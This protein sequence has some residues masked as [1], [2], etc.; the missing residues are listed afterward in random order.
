MIV[1][2]GSVTLNKKF[3]NEQQSNKKVVQDPNSLK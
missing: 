2:K 1:T 3:L